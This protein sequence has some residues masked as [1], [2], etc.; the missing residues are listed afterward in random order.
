MK[1][2]K[3]FIATLLVVAAISVAVVSC[4]KETASALT[5][6]KNESVQTFNPREIK[7]MNAYLKDFKQ[8]MNS[9]AKGEDESLSL[10]D[11]A[12]HLSSVANYDFGN[13]NVEFDDIRFDTLYA[14]V[15]V[16]NGTVLLSDLGI[17]YENIRNEIE[18]HFQKINLDEKHIRFIDAYISEDGYTSIPVIISFKR[19]SKGWDDYHWYYEPH[20]VDPFHDDI[21]MDSC[22]AHF[23]DDMVYMWDG[24]GMSELVRLL[25]VYEHHNLFSIG[26]SASYFTKTREHIFDYMSN[27]DPYGSPSNHNSRLFG[28]MGDWEYEIPKM[29]MCYYLDSYLGLGKQYLEDNPLYQYADECPAAWIVSSGQDVFNHDYSSTYYHILKVIYCYSY[30]HGFGT[31]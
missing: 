24:L 28:V 10:E 5:G 21:A 9:T 3:L 26:G 19:N 6:N 14:H 30:A 23:S 29:D 4:K 22:N 31:E 17:A 13:I 20:I 2:T 1:K 18:S 7:D 25:N 11:A 12:W 8:K 15:D 16:T 27:I